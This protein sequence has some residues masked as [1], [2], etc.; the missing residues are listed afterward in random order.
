V[1]KSVVVTS[2]TLLTIKLTINSNASL[3]A[4]DVTVN[5]PGSGAA[6][7]T[8]CFTV[9]PGPTITSVAPSTLPR[10]QATVVDILGTQ[11]NNGATLLLSG[12]GITAGTVTRVD[13]THLRVTLTVASSA[14]T[15]PRSI[16][17]TNTDAGKTT[18]T[19]VISVV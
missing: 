5:V 3:G 13:A 2:S 10:G 8:S 9:N 12:T 15:G 1:V 16:T 11:F 4:S 17:V 14:P 6:V 19:D 18:A 7:C